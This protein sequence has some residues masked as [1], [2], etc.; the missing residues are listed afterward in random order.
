ML[1]NGRKIVVKI[2]ITG[3]PERKEREKKSVKDLYS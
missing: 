1:F 3:V 2:F